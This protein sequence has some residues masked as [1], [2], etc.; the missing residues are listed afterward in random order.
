MATSVCTALENFLSI[1]AVFLGYPMAFIVLASF[2]FEFIYY[3]M[4]CVLYS[5]CSLSLFLGGGSPDVNLLLG[6]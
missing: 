3:L 1:F 6:Q 2:Y 5:I 4:A